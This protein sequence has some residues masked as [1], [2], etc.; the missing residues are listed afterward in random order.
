MKIFKIFYEKKKASCLKK[1]IQPP[2]TKE[3]LPTSLVEQKFSHEDL[4]EYIHIFFPSIL[5]M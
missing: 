3:E 4:Q 1:I 5:R 2:L